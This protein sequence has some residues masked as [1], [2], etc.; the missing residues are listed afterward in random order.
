MINEIQPKAKFQNIAQ[1]PL[2]FTETKLQPEN[3]IDTQRDYQLAYAKNGI[4][5]F[6]FTGTKLQLQ[7]QIALH[8]GIIYQLMQKKK[9][10]HFMTYISWEKNWTAIFECIS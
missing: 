5:S 1:C 4:L 2:N 6:N 8:K 7:S 3:K 10:R 9:K